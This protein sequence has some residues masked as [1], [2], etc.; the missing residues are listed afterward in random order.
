MKNRRTRLHLTSAGPRGCWAAARRPVH[1]WR[2]RQLPL[3]AGVTAADRVPPPLIPGR[4]TA[5]PRRG[6]KGRLLG[7]AVLDG[8]AGQFDAIVQLQ[9]AQRGLHVVLHGPGADHQG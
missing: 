9:F 2:K 3:A 8:V 4:R 6:L 5:A 7:E 1:R